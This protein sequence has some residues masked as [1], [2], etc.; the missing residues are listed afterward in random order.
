[1]DAAFGLRMREHAPE[2]VAA[3]LIHDVIATPDDDRAHSRRRGVVMF[4]TYVGAAYEPLL[5]QRLDEAAARR[6]AER[7]REELEAIPFT[8]PTLAA[9][10]K[11][12]LARDLARL[13]IA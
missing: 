7:A 9:A 6:V 4:D 5:Q 10:R 12:E 2:R 11:K 8:E 13:G 3:V 1:G